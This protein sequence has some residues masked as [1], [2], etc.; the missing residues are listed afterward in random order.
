MSLKWKL[1]ITNTFIPNIG[2]LIFMVTPTVLY[3]IVSV[4]NI[5]PFGGSLSE[6]AGAIIVGFVFTITLYFYV[7]YIKVMQNKK[8][9]EALEEI[10][11]INLKD[12]YIT[13]LSLSKKAIENKDM[14]TYIM[15]LAKSEILSFSIYS[16]PPIRKSGIITEKD[17]SVAA[18][19]FNNMK[20]GKKI[21]DDF[22]FYRIISQQDKN[23]EIF[24]SYLNKRKEES[25]RFHKGI[26]DFKVY[27]I[28]GEN[29]IIVQMPNFIVVDSKY[30]FITLRQ[31]DEKS[32][33][34]FIA[35]KELAESFALYF[36]YI[37]RKID[38]SNTNNL[39]HAST[40]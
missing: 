4:F 35:N 2:T 27:P 3:I 25:L 22:K 16:T 8:Y 28:N 24:L 32:R 14:A 7:I 15:E 38:Q 5:D 19:V 23:E 36:N 10:N 9:E 12:G 34:V 33:G 1:W 40:L 18:S 31:S 6:K 11:K 29:N 37:W 30:L 21:S 20:N 39:T 17:D 13:A 26:F